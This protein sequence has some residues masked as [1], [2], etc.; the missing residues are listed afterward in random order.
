MMA[1]CGGGGFSNP[2][3]PEFSAARQP[4]YSKTLHMLWSAGEIIITPTGTSTAT[5]EVVPNRGAQFNANV[6]RFLYPPIAPVSLIQLDFQPATNFLTAYVDINVGLQH[7][8]PGNNKYRG[9]DTRLILM[10]NS[11]TAGLHDP[12]VSYTIP[13]PGPEF[14]ID[15][16]VENADGLTR[17]WN[18]TEFTDTL[19]LLSYKPGAL[20]TDP[21]PNS[22]L[23]PYKYYSDDLDAFTEV[24]GLDVQSRGSFSANGGVNWRNFKIHFPNHP[25]PSFKFNYAVDT[26]YANPDPD[27]APEYPIDSFPPDAQVQEPYHV[28]VSDAGTD[29]YY[30]KSTTGTFTGGSLRM[31][32]EVFD[33]QAAVN[34]SG[35]ESEITSIWLEGSEMDAAVDVLP[36]AQ[37]SPGS[38]VTSSTFTI[39]IASDYFDHQTAGEYWLLGTVE[40][41]LPTSYLPQ[42]D[43]G[44]N[45]IY[46]SNAILSS[47]FMTSY[48]VSSGTSP[49]NVIQP[50]GGEAWDVGASKDITWAGGEAFDMVYI[51]Y[52]KDDFNS[53]IN[54]ISPSTE[55]VGYYN[56]S[57]VPNDI[58]NTVKVRVGATES[59][60]YNDTSDEY[61]S[62]VQKLWERIVYAADGPYPGRQIYSIDP[63]GLTVP[64]Q[65]TTGDALFIEDPHLSPDGRYILYTKFNGDFSSEMRL[66]DVITME[67]TDITPEGY[68]CVYGDFSHDGTRIVSAMGSIFTNLDMWTFDY[69]GGNPEQMTT[70]QFVW[71]P[72][73][74]PDDEYIAFQDFQ[75]NQVYIL[76]VGTGIVSQ[77]TNNGTWNDG[78]EYS[79]D[80]TQ[81]CWSTAYPLSGGRKIYVSPVSGWLPADYIIDFEQYIRAPAF[82]PDG[83]KIVFDHGAFSGSELAIYDIASDTWM[84]I[85]SNAF[86]DYQA[87]WGY[88]IPH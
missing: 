14:V 21:G 9:F 36:S 70:G 38:G 30:F 83:L 19:P 3:S 69:D 26:S 20:G 52:S 11:F 46:P 40:S 1:G 63:E 4:A 29:L 42:I 2:A 13:P 68:D 43:G 53:D 81:I 80:Q 8:F 51:E 88:M 77:W 37:V 16:Y 62:I 66:I 7:P 60:E 87:D 25:G 57:V 41:A 86:G 50:N 71:G 58:S 84:D 6:Q 47:Y 72:S 28:N 82:S 45:F 17:W 55:N 34:L 12:D 78:P 39:E 22:I 32:I 15:M 75:D 27:S 33:W 23:N 76:E 48:S 61:F 56:L 59:P 54:V 85:T 49:F 64:E 74:S 5:Y 10:A 73:Y 67:D 31:N 18:P 35:V 79:P 65:W 24:T 44:E